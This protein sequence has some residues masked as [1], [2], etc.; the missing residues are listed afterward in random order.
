MPPFDSDKAKK[1]V[2]W[3]CQRYEGH[4][5]IILDCNTANVHL[6]AWSFW[7]EQ[8]EQQ[9]EWTSSGPAGSQQCLYL[10][11]LEVASAGFIMVA[12]FYVNK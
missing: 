9:P 7:A 3:Q 8:L 12:R 4:I 2:L 6:T 1:G 10:L 5:H 11:E